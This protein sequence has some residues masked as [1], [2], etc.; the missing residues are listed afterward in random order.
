[1]FEI[2]YSTLG[3]IAGCFLLSLL[4]INLLGIND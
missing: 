2:L 1:M 3:T 4:I